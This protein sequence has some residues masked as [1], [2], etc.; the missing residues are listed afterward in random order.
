VWDA[1]T[2]INHLK[3]F[4]DVYHGLAEEDTIGEF[5]PFVACGKNEE[6]D[7]D[8]NYSLAKKVIEEEEKEEKKEDDGDI[9]M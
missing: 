8:M 6:L 3:T 2:K 7:S 4:E 1:L 5:I 9:K